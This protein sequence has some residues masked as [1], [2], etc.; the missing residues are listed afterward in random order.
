MLHRLIQMDDLL[1]QELE[2]DH[3]CLFEPKFK[4]F[5]FQNLSFSLINI[6]HQIE[7]EI[8]F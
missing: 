8:Q 6:H 1:Q 3:H 7:Q 2:Y 5:F 4:V